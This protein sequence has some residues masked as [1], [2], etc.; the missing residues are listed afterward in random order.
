MDAGSFQ[1]VRSVENL[2]SLEPI[3]S[4]RVMEIM[5]AAAESAMKKMLCGHLRHFP[6]TQHLSGQYQIWMVVLVD[7]LSRP[8]VRQSVWARVRGFQSCS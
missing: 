8:L 5:V 7:Y 4:S 2:G 1:E 6:Q 3:G